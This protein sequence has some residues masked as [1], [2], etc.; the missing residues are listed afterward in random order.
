MQERNGYSRP[1]ST[2]ALWHRWSKALDLLVSALVVLNISLAVAVFFAM[3]DRRD[4]L[5]AERVRAREEYKS[6]FRRD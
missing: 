6:H 3:M 5:R 2:R 4:R 1:N